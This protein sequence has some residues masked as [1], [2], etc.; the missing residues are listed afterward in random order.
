MFDKTATAWPVARPPPDEINKV[1][2]YQKRLLLFS[3]FAFGC[4]S[5]L[6]VH[7]SLFL[8][9][10]TEPKP[11]KHSLPTVLPQN[12]LTRL[13]NSSPR[14]WR[15]IR[16]AVEFACQ[17]PLSNHAIAWELFW[18]FYWSSTEILLEFYWRSVRVLL[19][20]L[21]D[22]FQSLR[23]YWGSLS[24]MNWRFPPK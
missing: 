4:Q 23:F 3:V 6:T 12:V 16:P 21:L 10:E 11:Q 9:P 7:R 1:G 17:F 13:S 20:G 15:S 19:G 22:S 8:D 24:E 18:W 5:A 14:S 2:F